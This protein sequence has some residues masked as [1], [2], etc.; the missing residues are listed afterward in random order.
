[1]A[2]RTLDDLDRVAAL[3]LGRIGAPRAGEEIAGVNLRGIE[4][5][6]KIVTS[7][8]SS[9][10]ANPLGAE[11]LRA[12]R[13]IAQAFD[14]QLE[15]AFDSALF[16]GD[17]SALSAMKGA[18]EAFSRHQAQFKQRARG[19]DAG[20][21]I[22]KMIERD[23]TPEEVANYILGSSRVDDSGLGVR[24]LDRLQNVFGRG[25]EPMQAIRGAA[26]QKLTSGLD[27]AAPA[28]AQK[29]SQAIEEFATGRGSTL[30]RRMFSPE[31]LGAM[32]RYGRALDS[33]AKMAKTPVGKVE[34]EGALKTLM[35]VSAQRLSPENLT[36]A[37]L[38][39][40]TRF[41]P[42]QHR[43]VDAVASVVGKDGPEW[44]ALRQGQWQRLT[45]VA[46][47][48]SPMGAQKMT[49]RLHEF[50]NGEGRSIAAKL[51]T[52]EELGQMRHFANIQRARAAKP[53][54]TN[55]SGSGNRLGAIA[56]KAAAAIATMLG[57]ST[58]GWGG[59]ALGYLG[60]KGI[61]NIGDLR[62]AAKA[63]KLFSGQEPARFMTGFGST[64]SFG[65]HAASTAYGTRAA[66]LDRE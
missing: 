57:A 29:L 38:G 47:G 52:P 2:A 17:E 25:S 31:E 13:G 43:L 59:A 19:N 5:A 3:N 36:G 46:E 1:M 53:G 9:A 49:E 23:A 55:P 61:A 56:N 60:G 58:G 21:T 28:G 7:R 41:T 4:Q 40:G 35:D 24:L 8:I 37:L 18:R 11:D 12:L 10:K 65:K 44:A 16:R 42:A 48:R 30:A 62:A 63:R 45:G 27:A 26:W 20:A 54:T 50:L 6:R 66:G 15:R 32:Q 39:Y 51:Y 22:Q 34:A 14:D 33:F 64:H